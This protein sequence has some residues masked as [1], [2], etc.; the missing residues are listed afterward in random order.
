MCF[1]STSLSYT[2][3]KGVKHDTPEKNE[4][5]KQ[6]IAEHTSKYNIHSSSVSYYIHKIQ[7]NC[8][9]TSSYI[10]T[11]SPFLR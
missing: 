4:H 5:T 2:G 1:Q 10:F 7:K 3:S 9:F 8:K 11:T 6:L